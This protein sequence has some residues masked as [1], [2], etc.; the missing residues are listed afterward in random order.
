MRSVRH[1]HMKTSAS[2]LGNHQCFLLSSTI[3]SCFFQTIL[4]I[5]KRALLTQSNKK[6]ATEKDLQKTKSE[7]SLK[8]YIS[9]FSNKIFIYN[10]K[11]TFYPQANTTKQLACILLQHEWEGCSSV[12]QCENLSPSSSSC[13]IH[14]KD[15][16]QKV[17][18][19]KNLEIV[20]TATKQ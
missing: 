9:Y 7:I 6:W 15:L 5:S 17:L 11:I 3:T 19:R 12:T 2:Q 10:I 4:H 8:F 16:T 14:T 18:L 20:K 13:T 1:M